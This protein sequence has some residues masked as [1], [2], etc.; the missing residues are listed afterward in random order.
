MELRRVPAGVQWPS[1]EVRRGRYL[2]DPILV[3]RSCHWRSTDDHEPSLAHESKARAARTLR[4]LRLRPPRY[5]G[6]LPGMRNRLDLLTLHL[7]DARKSK[8]RD[9]FPDR[10]ARC[11]SPDV[12][13]VVPL[14]EHLI[15]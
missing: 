4:R 11:I 7:L 10:D 14:T 1:P 5:A 13:L 8:R 12:Y 2:H 6:A 3:S 9:P 15:I